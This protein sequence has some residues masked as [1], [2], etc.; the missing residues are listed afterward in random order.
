MSRVPF[1]AAPMATL[2]PEDVAQVRRT[3]ALVTE[4][5]PMAGRLFYAN[6]FEVHPK[7][8]EMFHG[9][10]EAQGHKLMEIMATAVSMLKLPAALSPVLQRLGASH[11]GYGVE[12]WHYDAAGVA[13]IKTLADALGPDFGPVERQAWLKTYSWLSAAMQ[14]A[15]PSPPSPE[16]GTTAP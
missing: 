3:F 7:L 16:C 12:H 5:A 9:D 2:Q 6:L 15:A 13:L 14:A 11:A 4:A 1:P 8:R 10:L